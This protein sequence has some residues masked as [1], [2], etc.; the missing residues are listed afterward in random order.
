MADRYTFKS[1]VFTILRKDDQVLLSRR[2][3]TGW[4]DGFY[5]PP[6]GHLEYGETLQDAAVREVKE[7]TGVKLSHEDL[8]LV[9]IYQ[10]YG[11]RDGPYIGFMFSTNSWEGE[12]K[13]MEPEKCDDMQFFAL[14]NLPDK[15]TPYAM[16]AL[17]SLGDSEI[18]FSVHDEES[19]ASLNFAAEKFQ[20]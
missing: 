1:A 7:E 11:K 17:E 18:S 15:I 20:A 8:R 2:A 12:P 13:I 9:H 10:T 6:A 16:A 4:M 19:L 3:K 5:E 14:D